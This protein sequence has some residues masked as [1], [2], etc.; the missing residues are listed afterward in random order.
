MVLQ[1]PQQQNE[2]NS[3]SITELVTY[4]HLQGK[5]VL[6]GLRFWG[7]RWGVGGGGGVEWDFSPS[8]EIGSV[9][10]GGNA[11]LFTPQWDKKSEA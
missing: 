4:A 1:F 2:L 8:Q 10:R 6:F 3:T 5:K 9:H 11:W 7:G